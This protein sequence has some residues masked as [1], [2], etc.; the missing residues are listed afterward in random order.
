MNTSSEW[1]KSLS[2]S[3]RM[4]TTSKLQVSGKVNRFSG[5]TIYI[6]DSLAPLPINVLFQR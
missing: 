2:F 4:A 6:D 3:D 1:Q 5:C